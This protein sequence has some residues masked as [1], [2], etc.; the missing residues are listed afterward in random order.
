MNLLNDKEDKVI[1]CDVSVSG[2]YVVING[3]IIWY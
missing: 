2:A 1:P 3:K